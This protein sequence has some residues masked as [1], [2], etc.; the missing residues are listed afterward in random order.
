MEYNWQE[1]IEAN[2]HALGL[3]PKWC[4]NGYKPGWS[5][6]CP[7]PTH[8]VRGFDRNRSAFCF[9]DNGYIHCYGGCK[10]GMNIN[11]IT[12]KQIV[13]EEVMAK[14]AEVKEK[15]E[16]QEDQREFGDFTE[17]WL[18]LEPLD[19]DLDV[20]GV[21]GIELNKRG[22]RKYEGG[23]Y[24]PGLF[25]P[26]FSTNRSKVVF[27]QIRH[28]SGDRRFTFPVGARQTCY[29]WEQVR[30]CRKYLCFTEGSRDSVILGMVG[31]PAI[32]LPSSNGS[33][34]LQKVIELCRKIKLTPVAVCDRDEAGEKLLQ[35]VEGVMLDARSPVGKDI[36]DFLE[37]EGLEKVQEYYRKFRT[38]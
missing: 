25:I 38:F 9:A 6:R 36:G 37:Q 33:H 5:I 13:P 10:T 35:S 11:N 24:P 2:L 26:Y 15:R 14:T 1:E 19:N 21:P 20:K 32:A 30:K 7:N 23:A 12:G 3:D 16:V 29:G 18:E 31:V 28:L 34:L 4:G 22:W 17:M 8:N 27:F